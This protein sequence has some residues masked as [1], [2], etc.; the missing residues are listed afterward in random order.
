MTT[1]ELGLKA[2]ALF[3]TSAIARTLATVPLHFQFPPIRA[4]A[5]LPDIVTKRCKEPR[6]FQKDTELATRCGINVR[7]LL[8]NLHA[9]KVPGTSKTL[10]I[11]V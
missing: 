3:R 6:R 10:P 4:L 8:L 11:P 5:I 9:E 1:S 7:L 2:P